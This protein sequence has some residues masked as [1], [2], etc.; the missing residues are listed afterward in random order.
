MRIDIL[1]AGAMGCLFGALLSRANEV[2]L[3]DPNRAKLEKLKQAGVTVLEPDGTS[4]TV[5]PGLRHPE[6]ADMPPEVLLIFVKSAA[7]RAA[8]AAVRPSLGPD[9]VLLTL[10]NGMGH[11]KAMREI[12]PASHILLGATQHNA[13]LQSTGVVRHG[14][15]GYT[16]IGPL[17]GSGEKGEAVAAAFTAAGIR[18][19]V[20][21]DIR[22]VIWR[23]LF[24]NASA[25]ALTGVFRCP[26]G[27]VA[28][29][30]HIWTLCQKLIGEAVAVAKADG[31]AFD[32]G[33]I[34]EEI[35][36]HLIRSKG[37]I[38]SV[39]ADLEAGRKTE[40]DAITGAVAA[41]GRQLGVSVPVSDTVAEIIHAMEERKQSNGSSI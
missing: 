2:R 9:T 19:D 23:K 41:L 11:E 33:E 3:V 20:S 26:L 22:A 6:E 8:L 4:F 30:P 34:A 31:Y 27:D 15:Q 40:V 16:R 14:G 5:H 24:M 39:Y 35:H 28:E 7:E 1:G 37:G 18:T 25:S 12:A 36:G 29:N 32:E 17:Q 10:Q 38:T 13:S 21:P